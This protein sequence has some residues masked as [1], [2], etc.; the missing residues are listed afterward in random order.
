MKEERRTTAQKS[1]H[2]SVTAEI[3]VNLIFLLPRRGDGKM[4]AISEK[5]RHC[6]L[7]SISKHYLRICVQ[8]KR[9]EL[10]V[11]NLFVRHRNNAPSHQ[12]DSMQK[13]LEKNN[14]LLMPHHPYSP[15]L[16]PC[17]FLIFPKLKLAASGGFGRNK[18][19]NS[20][21]PAEHSQI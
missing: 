15:D 7:L 20:C 11:E 18:I 16:A 8:K 17:D 1:S 2:G 10:L 9:P 12:A 14:M 5:C 21:L 13:L 19:K 3:D 4:C 6:T